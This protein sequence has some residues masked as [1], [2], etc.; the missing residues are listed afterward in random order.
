[1]REAIGRSA[2]QDIHSIHYVRCPHKAFFDLAD[3]IDGDDTR[4]HRR[5]IINDGSLQLAA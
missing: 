2:L 5:R 4:R 3:I 1:V